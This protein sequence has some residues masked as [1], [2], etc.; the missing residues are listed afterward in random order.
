MLLVSTY[1]ASAKQ[2][3]TGF[4]SRD[5]WLITNTTISLLLTTLQT[6]QIEDKTPKIVEKKDDGGDLDLFLSSNDSQIQPALVNFID[7]LDQ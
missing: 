6:V 7:K 1:F 4:F 5:T 2:S 3:T